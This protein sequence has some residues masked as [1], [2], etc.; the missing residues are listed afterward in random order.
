MAEQTIVFA[1]GI[2][3]PPDILA[4]AREMKPADFTLQMLP[5][6]TSAGGDCPQHRV[7]D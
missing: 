2:E 3:M 4:L 7:R 6:S 1:Q 5:P